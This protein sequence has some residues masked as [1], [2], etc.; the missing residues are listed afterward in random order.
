MGKKNERPKER[1]DASKFNGTTVLLMQRVQQHGHTCMD[2]KQQQRSKQYTIAT[3]S[4]L[5]Y[6]VYLMSS[7]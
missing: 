5:I 3:T 6:T 1:Q 7:I 2:T 4:N